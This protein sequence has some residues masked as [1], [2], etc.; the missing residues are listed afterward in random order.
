MFKRSMFFMLLIALIAALSFLPKND[1]HKD[2][3]KQD[4]P[5]IDQGALVPMM[6]DVGK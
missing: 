6:G 3:N 1:K 2:G 4:T 5:W